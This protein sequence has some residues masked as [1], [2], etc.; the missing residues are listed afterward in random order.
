MPRVVGDE[1]NAT[2]NLERCL[3]EG[4]LALRPTKLNSRSSM[5]V[6]S[7]DEEGVNMTVS[8]CPRLRKLTA[9]SKL[10]STS[11]CSVSMES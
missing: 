4:M 5:G 9:R 10:G 11:S 2:R 8:S 7:A 1:N 6:T 3:A